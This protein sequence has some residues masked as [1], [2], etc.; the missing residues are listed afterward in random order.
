MHQFDGAGSRLCSLKI[1]EF[2]GFGIALEVD[3]A[4]LWP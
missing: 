4:S 2:S 3:Y 1:E